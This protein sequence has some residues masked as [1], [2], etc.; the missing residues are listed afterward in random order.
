[1]SQSGQQHTKA[2]VGGQRS[3]PKPSDSKQTTQPSV[4]E[5][6]TA[7]KKDSAKTDAKK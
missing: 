6:I 5:T 3:E 2:D 1:M 7:G 4:R